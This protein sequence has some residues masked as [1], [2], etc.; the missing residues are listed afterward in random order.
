MNTR[1]FRKT[2][3]LKEYERNYMKKNN[4]PFV[5]S[6]LQLLILTA[7]MGVLADSNTLEKQLN[8]AHEERLPFIEHTPL[9]LDYS[10]LTSVNIGNE[11]LSIIS[12]ASN[13]PAPLI[14]EETAFFDPVTGQIGR[15]TG[16]LILEA[17]ATAITEL[18]QSN[19]VQV[20]SYSEQTAIALVKPKTLESLDQL[21]N[22][23]NQLTG[24]SKVLPEKQLNRYRPL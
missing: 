16:R 2:H 22:T 19:R 9:D 10:T 12:D 15:L 4:S 3:L 5:L 17:T 6:G 20:L 18:K 23:L 11:T 7:S 21:S 1:I 14:G 8:Q 13:R 24:I